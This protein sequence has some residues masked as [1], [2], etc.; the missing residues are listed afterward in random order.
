ML[1]TKCSRKLTIQN[2]L[3]TVCKYPLK[4]KIVLRTVYKHPL[5]IK[6]VL[7]AVCKYPLKYKMSG[8]STDMTVLHVDTTWVMLCEQNAYELI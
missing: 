7:R 4:I 5:K 2:V 1:N 3:R 6:N 8:Y